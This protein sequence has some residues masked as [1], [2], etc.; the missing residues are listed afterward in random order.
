MERATRRA[1]EGALPEMGWARSLCDGGQVV[2]SSISADLAAD[3]DSELDTPHLGSI[4]LAPFLQTAHP[5]VA[6]GTPVAPSGSLNSANYGQLSSI[7]QGSTGTI[8]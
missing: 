5:I 3:Y 7:L 8:C 6:F 4:A 1:S 2:A